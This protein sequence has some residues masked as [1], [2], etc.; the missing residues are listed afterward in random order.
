MLQE[1]R[2]YATKVPVQLKDNAKRRLRISPN[3]TAEHQSGECKSDLG[4]VATTETGVP[5]PSA[6]PR[7]RVAIGRRIIKL[8]LL[9]PT[10]CTQIINSFALAEVCHAHVQHLRSLG[11]PLSLQSV[12]QVDGQCASAIQGFQ[13]CFFTVLGASGYTVRSVVCEIEPAKTRSHVTNHFASQTGLQEIS[14]QGSIPLRTSSGSRTI[15]VEVISAKWSTV[16]QIGPSSPKPAPWF[17][18]RALLTARV[19]PGSHYRC[20]KST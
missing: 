19:T 7:N 4:A 10:A 17:L 15:T 8:A 18:Q 6:A 1:E 16:G 11:R 20:A 2:T 12:F 3:A 5:F 13:A 9:S 14:L